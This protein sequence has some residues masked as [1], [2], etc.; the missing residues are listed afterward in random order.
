M[1]TW[2]TFGH[3]CSYDLADLSLCPVLDVLSLMSSP[4]G[5]VLAVLFSLSCPCCSVLS[6]L[7]LLRCPGCSVFAVLSLPSCPCY[8]FFLFFLSVLL[9]CP[10]LAVLPLLSCPCCLV[11]AI[12][13]LM[14]CP[15][16]RLWFCPGFMKNLSCRKW[17]NMI[18]LHLV[19]NWLG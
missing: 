6:V 17:N 8:P 1:T 7:S 14:Y 15:L 4:Y 9:F 16:C 2:P 11:L 10:V 19:V 5:P 3:P 13:S 18:A 12:Q